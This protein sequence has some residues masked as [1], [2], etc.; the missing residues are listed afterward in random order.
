MRRSSTPTARG[1]RPPAPLNESIDI[2]L[3]TAEPG[4][5]AFERSSVVVMER[6][7]VHSGVQT[8]R[9]VTAV[10]PTFAGVDP[11]NKWIDRNSD[12]NV[13]AVS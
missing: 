6:R 7:P 3:F 10:K 12:D 2:G 9:F 11:Y 4:K 13:K 8:F 5:K 1:W